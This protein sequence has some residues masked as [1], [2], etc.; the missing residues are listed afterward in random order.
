MNFSVLYIK[1]PYL[2]PDQ[3]IEKVADS[4]NDVQAICSETKDKFDGNGEGYD[5]A[6]S[7]YP[8]LASLLV[9]F[10]E[11]ILEEEDILASAEVMKI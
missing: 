4:E 2:L 1:K 9:R 10:F 11:A 5:V 6:S 7:Q 8:E 3:L